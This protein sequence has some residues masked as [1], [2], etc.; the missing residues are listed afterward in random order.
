MADRKFV[1][2]YSRDGQLRAAAGLNSP[3]HVMPY[4]ALLQRGAALDEALAPA[5][6]QNA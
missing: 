1:A 4:R 3:R 2:L 6:S 5:F